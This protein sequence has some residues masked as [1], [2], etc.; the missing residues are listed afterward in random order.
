MER[1]TVKSNIKADI[2]KTWKHWTATEHIVNW[3]T[4][5]P[6][7]H[8]TH[9]ENDLKAG[10]K[11]LSRMEAKDGSFGFDF[12]GTYN[13]VIPN[14]RITYT[15]DDGRKAE[16]DFSD[17]RGNTLMEIVFDAESENPVDMQRDGWQAILNS[18]A[19]YVEQK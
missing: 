9:A 13:E 6:D 2:E 8:T 14:Q 3:N 5:S 18:F 11:F 16:I 10:G 7:W 12:S 17:E 1:I 15:L 4:P 19:S